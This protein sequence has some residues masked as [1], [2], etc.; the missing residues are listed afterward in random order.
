MKKSLP[1]K[2]LHNTYGVDWQQKDL[3]TTYTHTGKFTLK[4][5]A[6]EFFKYHK[7]V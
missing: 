1:L 6:K 7:L 3:I 4:G 2:K 5:L